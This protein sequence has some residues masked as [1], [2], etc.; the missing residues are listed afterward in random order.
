MIL[1]F[2]GFALFVFSFNYEVSSDCN[3][4][5]ELENCGSAG[6]GACCGFVG[7]GWLHYFNLFGVKYGMD[8]SNIRVL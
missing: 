6:Y 8:I 2:V 7:F 4:F 1:K 5:W 3:G